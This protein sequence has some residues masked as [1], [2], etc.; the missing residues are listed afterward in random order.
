MDAKFYD[1]AVFHRVIEDFMI[2]GG[3]LDTSLVEQTDVFSP[4]TLESNNGL[5]NLRG[6]IAMART[7]VPDSAIAQFLSTVLTMIF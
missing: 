2:Q 1:N 5:K 3:G 6:T 7:S 4:I